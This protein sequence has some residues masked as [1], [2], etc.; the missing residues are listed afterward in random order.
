MKSGVDYPLVSIYIT[1]K[2]RPLLLKRALESL[3]KQ[4]YKNI[5]V[6]VFNDGSDII[7]IESY[8]KIINEFEESDL[9][10]K[11]Y[12]NL[13][14]IGACAAR[15]YMISRAT[16]KYVTGLDDDDFFFP[17]RI[18]LFVNATMDND[19]AFLCANGASDC[20]NSSLTEGG[21]VINFN[22]MKNYNCVGNQIFIEKIKL[23]SV[24]GFDEHMPAWQDYDT[25][26]RILK[27][28]NKAYKLKARTMFVDT[29]TER[30]RIST[31]SKAHQGYLKFI[32]KHKPLLNE[33][34]LL[35][36]KYNDL[37]NRK[38]HFSII[39]PYLL[40]KPKLWLRIFIQ[41]SVYYYPFLYKAYR[42]LIK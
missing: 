34:N 26:F 42:L 36:L 41:R 39:D 30:V 17:K 23:M 3:L 4:T 31:T 37:I 6:L 32:E 18:E 27:K 13:D 33:D 7:Y 9:Y 2:N 38:E 15:N 12:N 10:I 24:G 1:T 20:N 14:S 5:E 11:Y 40:K 25:W 29:N 19:Y 16:G 22:D 35:S 28:Y 8:A 21:F